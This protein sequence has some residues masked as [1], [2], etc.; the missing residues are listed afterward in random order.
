[1]YLD[2][3]KET[4]SNQHDLIDSYENI[5]KKLEAQ[6][7]ECQSAIDESTQREMEQLEMIMQLKEQYDALKEQEDDDDDDEDDC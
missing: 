4:M 5:T 2:I 1:M 3:V 7:H 6:I